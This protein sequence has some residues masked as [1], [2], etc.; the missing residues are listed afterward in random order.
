MTWLHLFAFAGYLAGSAGYLAHLATGRLAA[1]RV[2]NGLFVAGTAAHT[3][4]VAASL[5][6][7]GYLPVAGLGQT[8]LFAAWGLALAFV[9]VNWRYSLRVLGALAGPAVCLVMAA[10]LFLPSA[11][12][13]VEPQLLRGAWLIIHVGSLF[14]GDGALFL[15][16]A[17]GALYLLQERAIKQKSH[18]FVFRRLPSLGTLDRLNYG[19]LTIGF[20]LLT[21]GLITGA[22]YAQAVWGRWWSWDPKEMW[23]AITWLVYAALLH[24]RVMVGWRGRRAAILSMVGLLFLLFTFLGVNLLM[25]GHHGRF[26]RF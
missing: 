2:G 24:E 13:S 18:G 21:L 17:A 8:V 22:V 10:G 5:A 7:T 4:A 11:S 14:L 19:C 12:P 16:A 3:L 9:A 15:A 6:S 23:S 25:E 20:F 26:T 1:Y